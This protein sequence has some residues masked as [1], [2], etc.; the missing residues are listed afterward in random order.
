MCHT[1]NSNDLITH[2]HSSKD[3]I[4]LNHTSNYFNAQQDSQ[5]M[6]KPEMPA[7]LNVTTQK[8]CSQCLGCKPDFVKEA[9][10]NKALQE[11]NYI[12]NLRSHL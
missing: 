8:C 10:F 6:K 3:S 5:T 11:V 12:S 9:N 1:S 2:I 4:T 7:S